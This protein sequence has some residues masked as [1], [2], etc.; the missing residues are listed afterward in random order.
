M[1]DAEIE[2]VRAALNGYS[3]GFLPP[4]AL[5]EIAALL[6][7]V[8]TLTSEVARLRL[9]VAGF[10]E[11]VESADAH[12]AGPRGGQ[13]VPFHGDFANVGASLSLR[14]ALNWWVR[15]MRATLGQVR[16]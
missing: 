10:V 12:A 8:D 1:T 13:Q 5:E 16:P 15:T 14:T 6:E 11:A 3:A 7:E 2:E 9:V 4:R